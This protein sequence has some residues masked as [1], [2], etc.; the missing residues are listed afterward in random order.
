M[1]HSRSSNLPVPLASTG[2]VV[3]IQPS[4]GLS[5]PEYGFAEST[6]VFRVAAGA[7]LWRARCLFTARLLPS[8]SPFPRFFVNPVLLFAFDGQI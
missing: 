1:V 3:I 6:T 4:S 5:Q 8:L 7:Q 2:P